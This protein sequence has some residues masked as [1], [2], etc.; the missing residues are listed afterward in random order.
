MLKKWL[1]RKSRVA[2]YFALW[3]ELFD[4]LKEDCRGK[5]N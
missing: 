1:H 5:I 2:N 4:C 3:H